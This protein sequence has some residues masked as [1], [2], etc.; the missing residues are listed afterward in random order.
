MA[1]MTT[2]L[3]SL[4]ALG[5]IQT[6]PQ[7]FNSGLI[8]GTADPFDA[9][10]AFKDAL[11]IVHTHVQSFVPTIVMPLSNW[12]DSVA[13]FAGTFQVDATAVLNVVAAVGTGTPTPAQRALV[14]TSFSNISTNLR[15]LQSGVQAVQTTLT[16][17][18]DWMNT[19]HT[20]LMGTGPGQIQA[21]ITAVETYFSQYALAY[22]G[23]PGSD[24][25]VTTIGQIAVQVVKP[26]QTALTEL[27]TASNGFAAATAG[28]SSLLNL[29]Q[30]LVSKCD[31]VI[32]FVTGASDATFGSAIER[33]DLRASESAWSQLGTFIGNTI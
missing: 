26:L 7:A 25:I 18:V 6:G 16:Q 20:T 23:M 29:L 8:S 14:M 24:A 32:T 15:A 31:A 5:S 22:F 21:A 12:A 3:K 17:F 10:P 13:Q 9:N 28:A 19:D 1:A 4:N 33:I 11:N 30:D 27:Q 2:M